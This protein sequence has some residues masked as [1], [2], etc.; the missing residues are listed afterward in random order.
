MK[1][2]DERDALARFINQY[3]GS[4]CRTS[5][6]DKFS[7]SARDVFKY[8]SPPAQLLSRDATQG[9]AAFRARADEG[10]TCAAI[11]RAFLFP[12]EPTRGKGLFR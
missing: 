8:Y 3:A 10:R 5:A 2:T 7:V 1:E 4:S 6:A 9:S 11:R 12:P